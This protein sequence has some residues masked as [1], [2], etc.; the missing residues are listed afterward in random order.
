MKKVI[1]IIKKYLA[2]FYIS[3]SNSFAYISEVAFGSIFMLLVVFVMAQ[4]WMVVFSNNPD[5]LIAG[6][7]MENMV[8]YIFITEL[9]TTSKPRVIQ[10][11]GEEIIKGLK[12]L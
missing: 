6:F 2:I 5:K 10:I 12:F 9:I 3:I 11:L 1:N 7:T 4:I 8:W